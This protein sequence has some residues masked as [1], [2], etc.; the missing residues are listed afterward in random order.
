MAHSLPCI[1][2]QEGGIADIISDGETGYL[3]P[4]NNAEALAAKIECLIQHPTTAVDM[5]K[6]GRERFEREFTIG[7]F[8]E[9]MVGILDCC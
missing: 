5:G 4:R 9:R 1:S 2:T 7:R 8:E 3:V 6:A